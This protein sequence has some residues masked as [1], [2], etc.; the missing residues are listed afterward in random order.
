[1][2][3][4]YSTTDLLGQLLHPSQHYLHGLY[5]DILVSVLSHK[6]GITSLRL[7]LINKYIET[8][9]KR[10]TCHGQPPS[11]R[12][13][14]QIYP[15]RDHRFWKTTFWWHLRW[16]LI[17]GLTLYR[18]W[19]VLLSLMEIISSLNSI[20]YSYI[21]KHQNSNVCVDSICPRNNL[22]RVSGWKQLPWWW[23]RLYILSM[24]SE[25]G[26]PEGN[27]R[28]CTEYK[29]NKWLSPP[30]NTGETP[31]VKQAISQV[32]FTFWVSEA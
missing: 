12:R 28:N 31:L 32:I 29:Y 19:D 15:M 18:D 23:M 30:A 8:C 4:L 13:Y 27:H 17:V 21:T 14:I 22:I 16:S 5:L 3:I 6:Y 11:H 24:I 25:R 9:D 26:Q 2:C 20:S 7:H 1:M 10:P